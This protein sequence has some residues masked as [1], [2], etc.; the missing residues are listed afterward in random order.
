MTSEDSS[1]SGASLPSPLLFPKALPYL[2]PACLLAGKLVLAAL[3]GDRVRPADLRTL[4]ARDVLIL[5]KQ[6]APEGLRKE[7]HVEKL[8]RRISDVRKNNCEVALLHGTSAYAL[9]EKRE[10]ARLRHV[11]VPLD[12]T[13]LAAGLGLLV[14]GKRKI[15]VPVGRTRILT[16]RVSRDYLVL[17]V[18]FKARD[19]T[20]Q[21]APAGLSPLEILQ[22]LDGLDYVLLRGADRIVAGEHKG[23]IDLLVSHEALGHLKERFSRRI[24][25]A[26]VDAYTDD[27]QGGHAYKSVPY[28]TP[29]LAREMLDSAAPGEGGIRLPS[30]HWRFLAFCYHLMFHGKCVPYGPQQLCPESFTKPDYHPELVKLAGAANRPVPRDIDAMEALLEETGVMPSLDLIGFYSS[31]DEFLKKRYFDCA[32]VKPGLATFFVRDFGGGPAVVDGMRQRLMETFE[33]LVEGG[34]DDHNR[35]AIIHGV[36]GG[37]WSDS[38]AP[39]GRAEPV[40]WFVC[41]DPSPQPPSPRTRRKHPRVDNEHIRLKDDLRKDFGGGGTRDLRVIHSSDNSLEAV[42]H[43]EHL[44][45]K[46]HPEIARRLSE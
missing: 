35:H 42:N 34:V 22:L 7:T 11:L 20:R 38:A 24:G 39:G 33:I 17:E 12:L 8:Y 36:R 6:A 19:Q 9:V 16:H 27:G 37:N 18:R 43:L 44:G 31:K 4:G 32:P 26:S 23:D 30:P 46:D 45:L 28:F 25:T 3:A 5:E 14:Y 13:L 10:F 21:Y 2:E 29:P 41:W 40:H 1:T 15:L